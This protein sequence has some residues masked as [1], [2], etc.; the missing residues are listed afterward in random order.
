LI[1]PTVL[2]GPETH[3]DSHEPTPLQNSIDHCFVPDLLAILK[4]KDLHAIN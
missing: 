3:L 4:N 1:L 2:L